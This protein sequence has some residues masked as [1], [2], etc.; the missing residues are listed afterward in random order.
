MI[1]RLSLCV[2]LSVSDDCQ[3]LTVC[4][5]LYRMIVRLCVCLS[6]SDDCQALC[7]SVSDDCQA[8]TLC[9]SVCLG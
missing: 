9:V 2:C 8:L 5:C 7:V 1:V 3:D 6:V 4:V